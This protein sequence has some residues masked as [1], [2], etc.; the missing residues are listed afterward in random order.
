[1]GVQEQLYHK[2]IFVNRLRVNFT[3]VV[4]EILASGISSKA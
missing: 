2:T 4:S 1:M 3:F